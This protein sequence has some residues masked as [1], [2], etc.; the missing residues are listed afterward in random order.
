M[1]DVYVV[2]SA[3]VVTFSEARWVQLQADARLGAAVRAFRPGSTLRLKSDDIWVFYDDQ[4]RFNVKR[5][6]EAALGLEE[7]K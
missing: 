6:P 3:D 4:G 1:T 7:A 2:D 5:T